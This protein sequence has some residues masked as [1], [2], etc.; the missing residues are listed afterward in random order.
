MKKLIIFLII[1]LNLQIIANMSSPIEPG[2]FGSLPFISEYIDILSERLIIVPDEKFETALFQVEY[3]IKVNR[4]GT[5]IPLLFYAID[6]QGDF[7]IWVDDKI[8]DVKSIPERYNTLDG[9]IFKDFSYVFDDPTTKTTRNIA[10]DDTL[11]GNYQIY[12]TDL[13]YFEVDLSE[14]VHIIRVEYIAKRWTDNSGWI[15]KHSFR[16]ALE[17][18]KYWKS[19]GSLEI[20]LDA[21]KC[22]LNLSSNFG[23]PQEG[24]YNS[25]AVWKF[26]KLPSDVIEIIY[27]PEI[28]STAKTLIEIGP[29]MLTILLGLILI[30]IHLLILKMYKNENKNKNKRN[31]IVIIGSIFIPLITLLGFIFYYNIV[32]AF[33]GIEATERHGYVFMIILLYPLIFPVYWIIA[34]L[35]DKLILKRLLKNKI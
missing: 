16:Y 11:D 10:I 8:V 5:K 27:H 17:P 34:K 6:F 9:T 32:D 23:N 15:K 14:G 3:Q 7:K 33:I 21:S 4:N 22:K 20:I 1:F 24:G 29:T 31:T 2:S 35:I 25:I 28:N 30:I 18:A 13:K 12:L 19:F 26:E